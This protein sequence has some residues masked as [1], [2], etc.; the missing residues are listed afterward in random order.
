MI[1]IVIF[2]FLILSSGEPADLL[3][4]VVLHEA[5]H[6]ITAL[7]MVGELPQ[8]RFNIAGIKLVYSAVSG[9]AKRVAVSA[10]GPFVSILMGLIFSGK[11]SFAL[12]SLGLGAVN[13]LPVACLDGG[14]ILSA[15][16]ER[17]CS[18]GMSYKI[19]RYIS[20]ASSIAIF[21]LDCAVQLKC[22]ANISLAV[23]TVYL[24]YC[25]FGS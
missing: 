23:I 14:G 15:L 9:T 21:A 18:P 24:I 5:A 1:A 13:L 6:I 19:C 25:S 10:A 11:K 3:I 7:L 20:I 2:A 4:S 12:I 16:V 8:I 22:G 17:I